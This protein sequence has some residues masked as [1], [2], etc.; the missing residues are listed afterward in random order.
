MSS[1]PTIS[2]TI[3]STCCICPVCGQAATPR[4]PGPPSTV[5]CMSCGLEA[6]G[7]F[8]PSKDRESFYQENYYSE[9][10]GARFL[11][12]FEW[13]FVLFR[14]LRFRAISR[15]SARCG[16]IVDVGCGRGDLLETFKTHGW[17]VL[18][19]QLSRTAARAA[20]ER[21]GIEVVC[22][23]LPQLGLPR[24]RYDVVTFFHVLEH[25]AAPQAY[26]AAARE[27]LKDD[28][29]LVVEVPDCSSP[30]FRILGA[31]SFCFDYPH[32]LIFFTHNSLGSL[33][34]RA[35]FE[36]VGTSRFAI[37]YSPYTT[38]QNLL[39][40]LPGEPGRLYRALMGNVEGQSLRRS[41]WTWLHAALGLTLALPALFISL[42]ALALPVGNT[43][44][45]YCRKKL[46]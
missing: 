35:G 17:E 22:G 37:E 6:L 29:L 3:Q 1:T 5:L 14:W 42:L 45:F 12:L 7:S 15:R 4:I 9:E 25:L 16:A 31:R 10:T 39:N 32:H 27:L 28:G 23:E 38:L 36:I 40:I 13:P 18:G 33:L 2:G 41:P 8:P 30:G 24:G 11:K 26:L 19:T 34:K 43:V 20:K 44:R 21:R 46:G